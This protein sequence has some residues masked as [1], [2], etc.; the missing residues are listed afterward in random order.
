MALS[1]LSQLT[2]SDPGPFSV[3]VTVAGGRGGVPSVMVRDSELMLGTPVGPRVIDTSYVI[4]VA[5]S[6]GVSTSIRLL[7]QV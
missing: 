1:T 7:F 6:S 3:T 5:I 4:P 2:N